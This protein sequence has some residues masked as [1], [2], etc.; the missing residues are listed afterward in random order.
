[1]KIETYRYWGSNQHTGELF[2]TNCLQTCVKWVSSRLRE[3]A[4]EQI[5]SQETIYDEKTGVRYVT[6]DGKNWTIQMQKE[7]TKNEL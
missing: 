3:C 1:M 4:Q 2:N 6:D 7:V 5:H